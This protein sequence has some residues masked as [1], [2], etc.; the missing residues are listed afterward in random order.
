MLNVTTKGLIDRSIVYVLSIELE[1][2]M[3]IKVGRTSRNVEDRVSEILI[4]IWKKYRVFPKCYVKR[5]R[6]AKDAC[7]LE[8]ALHQA[9]HKYR[10]KTKHKFSGHTEMFEVSLGKATR[11]YD[12]LGKEQL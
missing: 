6:Q 9:L 5:Y 2:K 8:T 1:D 11:L 4:S 12:K 3:L 10:Y 7:K